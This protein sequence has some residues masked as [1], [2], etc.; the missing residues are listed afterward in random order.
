MNLLPKL[1]EVCKH[2]SAA[3]AMTLVIIESVTILE[4]FASGILKWE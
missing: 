1:V 3:Q 4:D 2:K